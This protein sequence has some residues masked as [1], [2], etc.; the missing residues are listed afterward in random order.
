MRAPANTKMKRSPQRALQRTV[1]EALLAL[2]EPARAP[3]MQAYM[4]SDM[5]FLGVSAARVKAACRGAFAAYPFEGA[6]A[7][8]SD[9]LFLWRTARHREER[10]AALWLSGQ[11]KAQPFQDLDALPMYEELIVTGA[12]WDYVD[13]LAEHRIGPLLAAYPGPMRKA[14]R[15]WSRSDNLWKRR[16]SI[17]CQMFFREA[18]DLNLLFSCIEPSLSSPE[19]FLRKAIGWALRQVGKHDPQAVRQYVK[20]HRAQLSGLSQREALKHLSRAR[21]L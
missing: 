13:E 4:K 11:R 7:W 17:I 6:L 3:A 14:M 10:Y 12:W 18:T 21:A 16:S 15:A 5:P 2:A 1:R 8:R 9:V 20:E 19:F